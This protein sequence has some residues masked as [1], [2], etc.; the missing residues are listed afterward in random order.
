MDYHVFSITWGEDEHDASAVDAHG[1]RTAAHRWCEL[2]DQHSNFV[3]GY[4]DN[5]EV[6]VID[7]NGKR[8][9]YI[10]GTDWSPDFHITDKQ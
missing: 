10:I 6:E 3:D 1:P 4:P 8:T 2:M 9:R 7:P 5:H